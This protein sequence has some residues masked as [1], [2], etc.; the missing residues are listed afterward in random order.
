MPIAQ[1]RNYGSY[2]VS[3]LPKDIYLSRWSQERNR[4][5]S[6][7]LLLFTTAWWECTVIVKKPKN[8]HQH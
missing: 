7:K 4:R 8:G 3:D 6:P 1:V 2:W 5:S